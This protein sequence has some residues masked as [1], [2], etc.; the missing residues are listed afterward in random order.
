MDQLWLIKDKKGRIFGPYTQKEV[1]FH[2]EEGEFKGEEFFSK[3]PTGTW[4]PLSA[5]PIFYE[6]LLS[7]INQKKSSI[8]EKPAPSFNNEYESEDVKEEV[9]EST[10]IISKPSIKKEK[11]KI[12][13]SKD[14]KQEIIEE[15]AVSQVIEMENVSKRFFEGLFESIKIP[16]LIFI[17]FIFVFLFG[18]F[19]RENNVPENK[20]ESI[21][22]LA[23]SQ[24][25]S[26][27][28]KQEIQNKTKIAFALYI[29]STVAHYLKAQNLY[30]QALESRNKPVSAYGYLCLVHLELWPFSSQNTKDKQAIKM[31]I[32]LAQ[33]FDTKKNYADLCKI[34]KSLIDKKF[35][36][37]LLMSNRI[38]N[39]TQE[40]N[41][42]FF[43]YLKAKALIGLNKSK[44]A[45]SYLQS[46]FVLKS[47]WIAPY[48]LQAEIY[49]R[50]KEYDLAGKT[51]QKILTIFKDHPSAKLRLGILEYKYF[52]K[53]KNSEKTLES[54]LNKL[55]D[56]VEPD[57]LFESYITLA[58]IYL[59]KNNKKLAIKY[60]NEAYA[61]D[62]VNPAMI[63]LK[64]QLK[65]E[66]NFENTKIKAR[67]LIYKGDFLMN[68]GNYSAAKIEFE[69]A[70]EVSRSGLAAFKLAQCYWQI[71]A[72]GQAIRWLKKAI[73]SDSEMLEAYFLL[74]N[75]LSSLFDFESALEV[76]NSVKKIS[77]SN[78]DLFKAYAL[79]SFRQ[80]KYKSTI[81]YAE[82]A[83][84]FYT[85]D[86]E[87]YILLSKSYLALDKRKKA[88][89]YARKAIQE[90]INNVTAQITYA[91]TLD[92]AN[93]DYNT[94]EYL[95]EQVKNFPS[96]TEYKQALGEYYFNKKEYQKAQIEF[97]NIIKL[98]SKFKPAYIFLGKTHNE[99]SFQNNNQ[100]Q[101]Y[102]LAEKYFVD[103]TLLDVSDP[104]PI[105]YLGK[106]YL[107]H[108]E[109][110]KAE[111][112]FEKILQINPNYPMI[113][114]Y[115]GLVNFYQTGENNLEK[116]LKFSKI[117][118]AKTPNNFLSYQ[119][120][121]DIYKLKSRGV[122]DTNQEKKKSYEL[123]VKEYQKALKYLKKDLEISMGL[124]ECYKGA[125]NLDLA[126]NLGKQLTKQKGLSGYPQV[127]RSIGEILEQKENYESAR[128][129]YFNYFQ[130][131]PGAKDRKQIET[132]IETLIKQKNSLTQEKKE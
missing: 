8:S 81:A 94:E 95:K 36:Q 108:E 19:F 42:I 84:K 21:R 91:L 40:I 44:E 118:S 31:T 69:K 7:K 11:V 35:E 122:F 99:L 106:S 117:Q 107:E 74:S 77:P 103:A 115:I 9:M 55:D 14:F 128:T 23:P 105:F 52:K 129:Y 66:A 82:R 97:E 47:K 43:Y 3:Y 121:G 126:L 119:L 70:Y 132:R 125:G 39:S 4:K 2:I 78:S 13:L 29:K 12:K 38:S 111:N 48:M 28:T 54:V 37:V 112:Q 114:Y 57:I 86:I 92:S 109:Y 6:K 60:S 30:V 27:I 20:V 15:E 113:Y 17:G 90:D 16:V 34:V 22:L 5:H 33:K 24:N 32:N 65:D 46:I 25:S 41:A 64:A 124:L 83:L 50:N 101:H 80:K 53:I 49:Y 26:S 1:C 116:A 98:Q 110:Q 131:K 56:W 130:L 59:Q 10:R 93:A 120:A 79:L 96:I 100:K 102:Q 18:Y 67:G 45:L 51:Y 88:F 85:F 62:P 104:S 76:L 127:Y 61:L 72:S 71:G 75:Y 63:K 58:N 89:S 87:I 68:Q 73:N 123:C